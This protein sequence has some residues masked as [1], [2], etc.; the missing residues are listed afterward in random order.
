MNKYFLVLLSNPMSWRPYIPRRARPAAARPNVAPDTVRRR[1]KALSYEA[2]CAQVVS[3]IRKFRSRR[4]SAAEFE[5]LAAK[6]VEAAAGDRSGDSNDRAVAW[7]A[8]RTVA[9]SPPCRQLA[10]IRFVVA[11]FVK[12]APWMLFPSIQPAELF[13]LRRLGADAL[14]YFVSEGYRI[15]RASW[16]TKQL[17]PDVINLITGYSAAYPERAHARVIAVALEEMGAVFDIGGV[18]VTTNGDIVACSY[19]VLGYL[20]ATPELRRFLAVGRTEPLVNISAS[21]DV[22]LSAYLDVPAV[23]SEALS[24]T[25]DT[26]TTLSASLCANLRAGI[27]REALAC[28]VACVQNI[29]DRDDRDA[30]AWLCAREAEN[31]AGTRTEDIRYLYSRA[32]FAHLVDFA[33]G[34]EE[35][36]PATQNM[37]ERLAV[38]VGRGL[39]AATLTG[40]TRTTICEM[41]NTAR[42]RYQARIVKDER[43]L[44]LLVAVTEL[45]LTVLPDA[46]TLGRPALAHIFRSS[47]PWSFGLLASETGQFSDNRLILEL[48]KTGKAGTE[49]VDR[50]C[51]RI[52]DSLLYDDDCRKSWLCYS[53]AGI[54]VKHDIIGGLRECFALCDKRITDSL[55]GEARVICMGLEGVPELV[56]ETV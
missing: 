43:Y 19:K 12:I 6:L 10:M 44:T 14:R 24:V 41:L 1:A 15:A 13:Q 32:V 23:L 56:Y 39:S 3:L 25:K 2:R 51:A 30:L 38:C 8:V 20:V 55:S 27:I 11:C 31:A 50:H 35:P 16:M 5:S 40:C 26:P 33:A 18:M 22:S 34:N 53:R 7:A 29:E 9:E 54:L 37:T 17:L 49:L 52:V 36:C 48:V 42:D 4:M 46:P 47:L 21:L 28:K 45:L